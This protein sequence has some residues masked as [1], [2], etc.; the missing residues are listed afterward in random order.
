MSED[1]W[2]WELRTN[3]WC[4]TIDFSCQKIEEVIVSGKYSEKEAI[5]QALN[6]V[7]V[8][9]DEQW[10]NLKIVTSCKKRVMLL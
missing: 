3:V 2:D 10:F 7:R 1:C 6:Y 8:I 4:V 9:L 5:A